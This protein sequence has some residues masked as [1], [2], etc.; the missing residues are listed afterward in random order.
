MSGVVH[1]RH[2][3]HVQV[4]IAYVCVPVLCMCTCSGV[5]VMILRALALIGAEIFCK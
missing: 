4:H 5:V 2:V 3:V 1:V